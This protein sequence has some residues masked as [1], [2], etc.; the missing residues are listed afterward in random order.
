MENDITF[1]CQLQIACQLNWRNIQKSVIYFWEK[2]NHKCIEDAY[3]F[4]IKCSEAGQPEETA[5]C[6][7]ACPASSD[8]ADTYLFNRKI[9]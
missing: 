1:W 7:L 6:R 5:L 2:K 9:K 3:T 4:P 8:S